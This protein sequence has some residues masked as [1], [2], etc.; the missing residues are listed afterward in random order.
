[1]DR[2]LRAL[3][4]RIAGLTEGT[5][6]DVQVRAVTADGDGPWSATA[7]GTPATWGAVRFFSPTAVALG[8]EVVV[9][10]AANGIGAFGAVVETLPPGF[11]YVSSSLPDDEIVV[12]G[13]ELRFTLLGITGFTYTVT[14]PGAAGSY[15]FS[16]VVTNAGGQRVP[17]GGA[18]NVAVGEDSL[19]PG[20]TPTATGRSRGTR[21]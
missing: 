19:S 14:A 1:M 5:R 17:V 6:Y 8:G 20:T 9:T 15:S 11:N 16:G 7:S 18:L 13:R 12:Q 10:V 2:R 4:Y 21:S 3:S